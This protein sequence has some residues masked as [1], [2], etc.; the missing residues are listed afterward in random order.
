M[1]RFSKSPEK[2]KDLILLFL[3]FKADPRIPNY[4]KKTAFDLAELIGF[5][6]GR[7]VDLFKTDDPHDEL[8]SC[9]N[10]INSVTKD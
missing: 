6:L 4:K 2:M 8:T 10:E 5:D 3:S 7:L 1:I 9:G